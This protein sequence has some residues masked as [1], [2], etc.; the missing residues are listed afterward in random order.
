MKAKG[1][2]SCYLTGDQSGWEFVTTSKKP[3]F[4]VSKGFFGAFARG[5]IKLIYIMRILS[6][7]ILCKFKCD[8]CV[9]V[10]K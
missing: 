9:Q 5:S 3:A 4:Q 6:I 1:Q 2:G 8:R 7:F 10:K